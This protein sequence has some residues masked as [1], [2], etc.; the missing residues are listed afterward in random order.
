MKM[1]D[2]GEV[3]QR[4]GLA[5]STLRYYEEI[6]LIK[7]VARHG[8]RRQ[9]ESDTLDQLALISLGKAAGFSLTEVSN[10]FGRDGFSDLP[11]DA[12]HERAN[13]LD[14]QIRR[15]TALSSLVRH[16][17]DC[18]AETHMDCP[19]FRKLMRLAAKGQ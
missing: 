15:L 14:S 2:I 18:P 12:L 10:M 4:S 5:P 16:V 13:I 17:A 11:R 6:G 7:P 19:K 1:I 9:Y 3:A 8:L